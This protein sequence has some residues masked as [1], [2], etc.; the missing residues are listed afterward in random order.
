MTK[1]L[2]VLDRIDIPTPC[3][4]DWNKMKGNDVVRFCEHCNLSVHDLSAMTQTKAIKLVL[5]SKGR[6]CARY[7][8][9]PDGAIQHTTQKVY[10]ISNRASRIA[11]GVFSAALSL[12]SIAYAQNQTTTPE[13]KQIIVASETFKKNDDGK[14]PSLRGTITDPNSAVIAGATI[15]AINQATGREQTVTSDEN[16]VYEFYDLEEGEY[17]LTFQSPGFT[18]KEDVVQI[19]SGAVIEKNLQLEVGEV[20]SGVIMITYQSPLLN[21]VASGSVDAV[22]EEIEKGADLSSTVDGTS[23]L[24]LAVSHN[25]IEIVRLLLGAGASPNVRDSAKQTPLMLQYSDTDI[26]IF[27]LL[28]KAGAKVNAK[29]SEGKTALMTAAKNGN[30]EIVKLLLRAGAKVN[31]R[32]KEGKTAL[33]YAKEE[34][35]SE[36]V[37]L[38]KKHGATEEK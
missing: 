15:T 17:K 28:I 1:K 32:D 11:A 24:H 18:H 19:S 33:M 38:L 13:E 16:G 27:N 8:K 5:Q 9:T 3:S 22:K 37:D 36:I 30:I 6:L 2:S 35:N 7:T 34:W 14:V 4:A 12:S 21:A 31:K 10:Q 20:L 23:A 25:N 26:E 29:D